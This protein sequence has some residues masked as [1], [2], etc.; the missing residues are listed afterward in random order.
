MNAAAVEQFFSQHVQCIKPGGNGQRSARC[1]FHDDQQASLSFNVGKGVWKCHACG[2]Q[3]GVRDFA[4]ELGLPNNAVPNMSD[5]GPASEIAAV[6]QYRDEQGGLLFEVVRFNPKG[7]RQRRPDGDGGWVWKL[8]GVR[9]VLYRLP[10]LLAADKG[11]PVFVVEGEKDAE[12]LRGLG[13]TATCNSGGAGKWRDDYAQHFRGLHVVVIPDNDGPGRNHARQVAASLRAAAAS[14]KLLELPG[15]T[16]KG[17]DVSDWLAQRH[18]AQE[19][20]ELAQSAPVYSD[21]ATEVDATSAKAENM[22]DAGNARRLVKEH[23]H[24]LRYCHAWGKWLVWDGKRWRKDDAGAVV[25]KTKKTVRAIYAEA[26]A[27]P[28]KEQREALAKWARESERRH[29]IMDLIALAQSEPDI[30]VAPP[31]LDA[32]PFLLNCRNG[33]VDLRTGSLRPH[34]REDSITK[35]A[36][37]DYD[38]AARLNLWDR[39]LHTVTDGDSEMLS[40]LQRAV[41]YS[42]TGDT[43]EEKLFMPHGP[44]ATGKSTFLEAFKSALGEYA[45]TADFEAFLKRRDV[46]GPRNDIARLAGARLVVSIEVDEGK[47]LAEGLVKMLTGGDTVAA[48]FLHKEAFEFAPQFKLWLAANHEPT[49]SDEDSAM[50]RRILRIPFEHVIPEDQRDPGIKKKL[51]NPKVAGPAILAWAV[52]GCLAWKR[53]GLKVPARVRA[54]TEAYRKDMDPLKEWFD[55]HCVLQEDAW[56]SSEALR[57]SYQAWTKENS[58]RPVEG[59]GFGQRLKDRGL[60]DRKQDG[61]RGWRGVILDGSV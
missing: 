8:D 20:R 15:L 54:A 6:Y 30:P 31:D 25:E 21:E 23:G 42:L 19:L 12:T 43:G 3:G 60:V 57:Q 46:G 17:A 11:G 13:L 44:G 47:R 49:V 7:F 22:T 52:Q 61:K 29:R 14:V 51:K 53:D 10:E 35:I 5:H 34:R 38:P 40:F 39:F 2:K 37:V 27:E 55:A 59:R 50:W 48:R 26:A 41:G 28:D 4:R 58:E 24:D 32:D 56:T 45:A 9:R 36:P 16:R 18:T 33:T 1:P